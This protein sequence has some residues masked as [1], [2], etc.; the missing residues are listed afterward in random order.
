MSLDGLNLNCKTAEIV[1]DHRKIQDPNC[2]N[3]LVIGSCGLHVVHGA[4]RAR[5]NATD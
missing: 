1:E 4:Y 2:P 3:L 5:Q